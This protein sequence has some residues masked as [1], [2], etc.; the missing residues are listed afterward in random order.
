MQM[1]LPHPFT[2]ISYLKHFLGR[3]LKAEVQFEDESSWDESH[4]KEDVEYG[5]IVLSA[6]SLGCHV[7]DLSRQRTTDDGS[8]SSKQLLQPI[9]TTKLLD[10]HH[11]CTL[12]QVLF[13]HSVTGGIMI[14]PQTSWQMKPWEHQWDIWAECRIWESDP[15]LI[16]CCI[17]SPE[18]RGCC[19][20]T[21]HFHSC[22]TVWTMGRFGWK[23]YQ[24]HW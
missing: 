15:S 1:F 19:S 2:L 14:L 18:S 8:K 9:V 20:H 22:L 13:I 10:G 16:L 24:R 12:T 17:H 5:L 7:N 3:L 6:R 11:H 23:R 4:D 21:G